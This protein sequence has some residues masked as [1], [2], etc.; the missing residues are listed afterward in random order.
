[1]RLSIVNYGLDPGAE[2]PKHA[3]KED[4]ELI[5]IATEI[6]RKHDFGLGAVVVSEVF[7]TGLKNS[8]HRKYMEK[9]MDKAVT[10]F[11]QPHLT[12]FLMHHEMGG[13]GMFSSGDS[14][15]LS[16]G[17][18][19]FSR[20]SR[21]AVET[22]SG[23]ATGY[24]KV[25]TFIPT[26]ATIGG[27]NAIEALRSRRLLTVS[28][29]ARVSDN[30]YRCSI[31]GKSMYDEECDHTPGK[32]YEGAICVAE[33]FN[34]WFREYSVVYNPSD[35]YATV[36]RMD[37]MEG[38]IA[39]DKHQVIDQEPS[40]GYL[41][42]YE[43]VGK[44]IYPSS[45][46][47]PEGGDTM[48]DNAQGSTPPAPEAPKTSLSDTS[49]GQVIAM[50]ETKLKEKDDVI[51]SLATALRDRIEE[52]D[53][54]KSDLS[55][56]NIQPQDGDDEGSD[57]EETPPDSALP[58]G[59][60]DPGTSSGDPA[61]GTSNPAAIPDGAKEPSP[62]AE[63][64]GDGSAGEAGGSADDS[65][66]TSDQPS[67]TPADGGSDTTGKSGEDEG[68]TPPEEPKDSD[69]SSESGSSAES[70]K[71]PEG[72]T[73]IRDALG[74]RFLSGMPPKKSGNPLGDRSIASAIRR[75]H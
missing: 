38:E 44:V 39:P 63:P 64:A 60:E 50:Y 18:N 47:K 42:V 40:L 13:G 37:V 61:G 35:I 45:S 59:D 36:R 17:S 49:V 73:D 31:C 25:A 21:R 1:M 62:Q 53:K 41:H 43:E 65:G 4:D 54:L 11:F 33:V 29:G 5:A 10:T 9:G 8:N 12:P 70:A 22:P 20:Y 34:P 48:G 75:N 15:L 69:G 55:L 16:V 3:K 27:Q 14:T 28:L 68:K 23:L 32:E 30:D 19:I 26:N 71:K 58:G 57:P 24:G 7:H 56:G 46:I 67:G 52:L 66:K 74:S 2:V 6:I 72:Q 51:V